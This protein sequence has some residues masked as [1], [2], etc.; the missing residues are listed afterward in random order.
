MA[1]IPVP[2]TAKLVMRFSQFGRVY[3]NTTYWRKSSGWTGATLN[4]LCEYSYLAWETH[5]LGNQSTAVVMLAPYAY[6]MSAVDGPVGTF[7]P[8]STDNGGNASPALPGNVTA[9]VTLRTENRGKSGRGRIYH[10]GLTEGDVTNNAIILAT[11]DTILAG[12]NS[13]WADTETDSVSDLGVVSFQLD[14]AVRNPG[15]FQLV[16]SLAMDEGIDTQRR[17]VRPTT[18]GS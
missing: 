13:W 7:D 18:S 10:V 4:D 9:T 3:T 14:G 17:R 12:Y 11:R 1:F 16:T 2:D 8:P 15:V 6:D 5:I